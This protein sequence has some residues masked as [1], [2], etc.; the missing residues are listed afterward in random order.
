MPTTATVQPSSSKRAGASASRGLRPAPTGAMSCGSCRVSFRSPRLAALLH[1]RHLA[2]FV[3]NPLVEPVHRTAG[4]ARP[5]APWALVAAAAVTHAQV[6]ETNAHRIRIVTVA[7]GLSDSWSIAF[8]PSNDMLVTERTGQVR[9]IRNGVL[10][11]EPVGGPPEVR[12]RN[13]GGLMDIVLHP[14]FAE[15]GFVYLTY[16]KPREKEATTAIMRAPIE[17][18]TCR[19]T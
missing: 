15:N 2:L 10:Q 3:L 4:L 1:L 13:H 8:L 18:D 7:E 14:R 11:P 17:L 12:Y 19:S 5:L 6:F 16:S 9:L